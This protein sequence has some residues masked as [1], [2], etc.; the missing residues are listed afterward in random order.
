[1][2]ALLSAS[3]LEGIVDF[4]RALHRAGFELL[5]TGGTGRHW[6]TPGCR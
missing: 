4:A 1:M 6:R 3:N 2:R 5:S